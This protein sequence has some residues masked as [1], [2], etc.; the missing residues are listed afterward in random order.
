MNPSPLFQIKVTI[1]SFVPVEIQINNTGVNHI[2][3]FEYLYIRTSELQNTIASF[4]SHFK[5]LTQLCTSAFFQSIYSV[6]VFQH[7]KSLS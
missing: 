4:H 6:S 2:Y 1:L 3:L 5:F 7:S